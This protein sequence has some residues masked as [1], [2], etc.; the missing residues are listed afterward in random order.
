MDPLM[1]CSFEKLCKLCP[2]KIDTSKLFSELNPKILIFNKKHSQHTQNINN[3]NNVNN[4][5]GNINNSSYNQPTD[6]LLSPDNFNNFNKIMINS[7][8]NKS[9]GVNNTGNK[10]VNRFNLINTSNSID[11][12]EAPKFRSF[13]EIPQQNPNMTPIVNKDKLED[14]NNL[15][16]NHP[17]I[18]NRDNMKPFTYNSSSPHNIQLE[19][20]KSSEVNTNTNNTGNNNSFAKYVESN[21][22]PFT[23]H[24]SNQSNSEFNNKEFTPNNIKNMLKNF[25]EGADNNIFNNI[26][27]QEN[28]NLNNNNNISSS[29][30]NLIP[31][32]TYKKENIFKI[33]EITSLKMNDISQL[34]R[35]FGEI[36]RLL[37]LYHCE[38]AAN[39][40]KKLPI[41][42]YRSGWSLSILGRCLFESAKYKESE[43]VFKECLK[44]DNAR[45]EGLEYYSSCLWHLKDQFQ[46]CNL[47]NHALE[48]SHFCP[49]T[50]II[51]GNCYSLQK[52][53]EIAIKFF[54]RAIQLESNFA[55]AYT[56]C[57]HEYV[58]NESYNQAKDCYSQAVDIDKRY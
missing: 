26:R 16:Y 14:Y 47:A 41:N 5:H 34:L 49:E 48:T 4:S 3:I 8:D 7:V 43:K 22:K 23:V 44:V 15:N 18:K 1:W 32:S 46:L 28:N 29:N 9:S 19:F 56:L 40:I 42:Q 24:Q 45:L 31:N 20:G 39:I 6:F 10:G 12:N 30:N 2:N 11:E 37:C 33:N 27:L 25:G 21:I 17:L 13:L 53:H 57:G 50:W 54:N 58:D 36:L 35:H 38:E 52:E 51:V 55:Y